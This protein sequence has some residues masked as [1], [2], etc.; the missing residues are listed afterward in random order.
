ME[1]SDLKHRV[2]RHFFDLV[3]EDANPLVVALALQDNSSVGLQHYSREFAELH[4]ELREMLRSRVEFSYQGFNE[5]VGVYREVVNSLKIGHEEMQTSK[6]ALVKLQDQVTERKPVLRDLQQKSMLYKQKLDILADL[7]FLQQIP[8]KFEACVARKQF[9]KARM[10]LGQ[11]LETVTIRDLTNEPSIKPL[12]DYVQTQQSQLVGKVVDE[13][14]A[15]VYLTSPFAQR[16][17][18]QGTSTI[19]LYSGESSNSIDDPDYVDFIESL[20]NLPEIE[21]ESNPESNSFAYLA[22]LI[23]TLSDLQSLDSSLENLQRRVPHDLNAMVHSVTREVIKDLNLTPDILD[24]KT[25]AS[26]LLEQFRSIDQ[27]ALSTLARMLFLR[28]TRF[29][30]SQRAIAEISNHYGTSYDFDAACERTTVAVKSFVLSYLGTKPSDERKYRNAKGGAASENNKQNSNIN[31]ASKRD[32]EP[33]FQFGPTDEDT[34]SLRDF[35]ALRDTIK[36][37][38]PGLLP[39]DPTQVFAETHKEEQLEVVAPAHILNIRPLLEPLTMFFGSAR[40]IA[41]TKASRDMFDNFLDKFLQESF[42]P[43]LKEAFD[44]AIDEIADEEDAFVEMSNWRT[45]S[46]I[47]I[48]NCASQFSE[49]LC[50]LSQLLDTGTTYREEYASILVGLLSRI[51]EYFKIHL[52]TLFKASTAVSGGS[53]KR[54]ASAL[55]GNGRRSSRSK[56]YRT[57]LNNNS[58]LY[59]KLIKTWELAVHAPLFPLLEKRY[60]GKPYSAQEEFDIYFG[61]RSQPNG[62]KP[63]FTLADQMEVSSF[64]QV[65]L[66]ITSINWIVLRL[67]KMRKVSD[68]ENVGKSSNN[69]SSR[70]RRRWTLLDTSNA[71]SVGLNHGDNPATSLL[72]ATAILA[73]KTLSQY[74]EIVSTLELHSLYALCALRV[75]IFISTVCHFDQMISS[76]DFSSSNRGEERDPVVDRMQQSLSAVSEIFD[77]YLLYTDR[78]FILGGIP[79][80]MNDLFILE[81]VKVTDINEAGQNQLLTNVFALQQ[82]LTSIVEDPRQVD[83]SRASGFIEFMRLNPSLIIDKVRDGATGLSQSDVKLLL[84]IRH[85]NA[86]PGSHVSGNLENQLSQLEKIYQGEEIPPSESS[87]ASSSKPGSATTRSTTTAAAPSPVKTT[88]RTTTKSRD[89][90]STAAPVAATPGPGVSATTAPRNLVERNRRRSSPS[91]TGAAIQPTHQQE[92]PEISRS[93]DMAQDEANKRRETESAAKAEELR[94]ER[95]ALKAKSYEAERQRDRERQRRAEEEEKQRVA[96]EENRRRQLLDERRRKQQQQ[97][98]KEKELRSQQE[99]AERVAA[100]KAQQKQEEEIKARLAAE[101]EVN[102]RRVAERQSR[103]R[104]QIRLQQQ[105]EQAEMERYSRELRDLEE[106]QQRSLNLSS[107]QGSAMSSSNNTGNSTTAAAPTIKSVSSRG[108]LTAAAPSA[109]A[110]RSPLLNHRP[111]FDSSH[112]NSS[113]TSSNAMHYP[114]SQSNNSSHSVASS[115]SSGSSNSGGISVRKSRPNLREPL[116]V[117]TRGLRQDD[118]DMPQTP[119]Q[120]T[121]IRPRT[122]SER[123]L[124]MAQKVRER[125]IPTPR[126]HG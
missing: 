57:A 15:H 21:S 42:V 111:R 63:S 31:G 32:K 10:L 40:N 25:S 7:E 16:R 102:A 8:Q 17:L 61:K 126:R 2:G 6:Q 11:S 94:R 75:D 114:T 28:F 44:D 98:Q 18:V 108:S 96:Q 82:M 121:S 46:Q 54:N 62:S 124:E 106:A 47:P 35:D 101:E 69:I 81:A 14:R 38:V 58:H 65:T 89:A 110:T 60:E 120:P 45:K 88:S 118:L 23:S 3:D 26:T 123:A 100:L 19:P 116:N 113:H 107:E 9:N 53:N 85:R 51:A 37:S 39:D 122:P 66:L 115:G 12:L 13:I 105:Q 67:R 52:V 64:K 34:T 50:L 83:F 125:Q 103:D 84:E 33:I 97:Q 78:K 77:K 55:G 1:I 76:R 117:N 36:K 86:G 41:N 29:L 80:F 74:D 71:L 48:V 119:D 49:T 95:E 59:Q 93:R 90:P 24:I 5:S 79:Q 4:A 87:S 70:V 112:S 73:G 99:E 92:D 72:N 20:P 43:R 91:K 68:S 22:S 27:T 104:E 109:G 56:G 30:E